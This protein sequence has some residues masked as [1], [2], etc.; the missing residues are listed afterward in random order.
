MRKKTG[1][2]RRSFIKNATF[3]LIGGGYL[4]RGVDPPSQVVADSETP[5]I[6][7]YRTLGRTGFKVSDLGAGH[8]GDEGLLHA[9]L[10]AGVNYIDT[11]E[12]YRFNERVLGNCE[13]ACPYGVPVQ[14][15]LATAHQTLSLA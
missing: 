11:S 14:V 5:R 2:D 3:G 4:S 15:L 10:D 13:S 1:L 9:F 12:G 8:V 6:K 7:E